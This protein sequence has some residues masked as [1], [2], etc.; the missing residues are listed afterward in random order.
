[1][2]FI[3]LKKNNS[4]LPL[5]RKVNCGQLEIG[6]KNNLRELAGIMLDKG[7]ENVEFNSYFQ[8][9]N[10]VWVV[11][12]YSRNNLG[13]ICYSPDKGET[14]FKQWKNEDCIDDFPTE[15]Y[16]FDK[17][18]G[19]STTIR[20]ILST[21][22]GGKNW[23]T[24]HAFE[25]G[26]LRQFHILNRNTLVAQEEVLIS[27]ADRIRQGINGRPL[28]VPEIF[29]MNPKVKNQ[30]KVPYKRTVYTN[31]GGRIWETIENWDPKLFNLNN[32]SSIKLDRPIPDYISNTQKQMMEREPK[33]Y[34]Y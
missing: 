6:I 31:N 24:V 11:G 8:E 4:I 17:N 21:S 28:E 29:M 23:E 3:W 34:I 5:Q 20:R 12:R 9:E 7:A 27:L 19:L 13:F 10:N 26:K 18:N 14:W 33:V 16:F 1:M 15:I 30:K 32:L 22:N 25:D 2:K